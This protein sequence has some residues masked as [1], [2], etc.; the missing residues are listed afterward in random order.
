LARRCEAGENDAKYAFFDWNTVTDFK[1]RFVGAAYKSL[2]WRFFHVPIMLQLAWR[3]AIGSIVFDAAGRLQQIRM[4]AS[5]PKLRRA[6]SLLFGGTAFNGSGR[7]QDLRQTAAAEAEKPLP[8][9]ATPIVPPTR[10][11]TR[12][13][14]L[15]REWQSARRWTRIDDV[16]PVLTHS[17]EN[18]A[19]H[20][21]CPQQIYIQLPPCFFD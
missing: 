21:E 14:A 6:K 2:A 18:S 19:A 1:L 15:D 20:A 16:A 9:G 7:E 5:L 17:R 10:T 12:Y 8:Y 13:T 4:T 11:W 3:G